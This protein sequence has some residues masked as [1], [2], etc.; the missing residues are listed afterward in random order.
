[1]PI[2]KLPAWVASQ[3]GLG[4][5]N[6][7]VLG[8]RSYERVQYMVKSRLKML[9]SAATAY[10]TSAQSE[11]PAPTTAESE[12]DGPRIRIRTEREAGSA[13]GSSTTDDSS[14]SS[15]SS[16]SLTGTE[17]A[18]SSVT[19]T[20]TN[21]GHG[22]PSKDEIAVNVRKLIERP[23][24]AVYFVKPETDTDRRIIH[25]YNNQ[26][27]KVY[28]LLRP[29]ARSQTWT[30][31]YADAQMGVGDLATI[32][33]G[34]KD[35][36]GVGTGI[37]SARAQP[38]KY[39]LFNNPNG[40]LTY[41]KVTKQWTPEDGSMRTFYLAGAAPYHWTK[42]GF[43]QKSIFRNAEFFL[44]DPSV[45]SPAAIPLN[46]G[47]SPGPASAAWS[48]NA[49]PSYFPTDG[50]GRVL[51]QQSAS[52]ANRSGTSLS[53]NVSTRPMAAHTLWDLRPGSTG[54]QVNVVDR[55]LISKHGERETI[56]HAAKIARGMT[57][58]IAVDTRK[59][60]P[61]IVIATAWISILHQWS[62]K[63]TARGVELPAGV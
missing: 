61:E 6:A 44:T 31:A 57:W 54:P 19:T 32:Y 48:A 39:I 43:L 17:N 38:G 21:Q 16:S 10:T 63:I 24:V 46:V 20:L 36:V 56:A 42:A 23:G 47:T 40:G 55:S 49:S 18:P 58:R 14:L 45:G 5:A 7:L 37:I 9:T 8:Y 22:R 33:A 15:S 1:M 4:V 51:Q 34:K 29:D 59:I 12:S 41:R 35:G 2:P 3:I 27:E 13:L 28:V 60:S 11:E 25:I 53:S 52:A 50:R 62:K 30:L 26:G